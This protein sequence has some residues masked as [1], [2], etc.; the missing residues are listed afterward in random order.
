MHAS[1]ARS[2][3]ESEEEEECA[4]STEVITRLITSTYMQGGRRRRTSRVRVERGE[5]KMVSN[6]SNNDKKIRIL[7]ERGERAGGRGGKT[8]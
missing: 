7:V 6:N 3:R 8:R 1:P 4:S 2:S 5:N